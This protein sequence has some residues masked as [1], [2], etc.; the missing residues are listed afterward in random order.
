M[1]QYVKVKTRKKGLHLNN[2][3]W[4][5]SNPYNVVGFK[6]S[7]N[8]LQQKKTKKM[9]HTLKRL[10]SLRPSNANSWDLV[11]DGEDLIFKVYLVTITVSKITTQKLTTAMDCNHIRSFQMA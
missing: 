3:N 1:N 10:N 6:T 11:M 7:K 8:D 9:H 5:A 2:S 4:M